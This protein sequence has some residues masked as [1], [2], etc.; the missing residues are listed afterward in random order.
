MPLPAPPALLFAG[1]LPQVLLLQPVS[2][3]FFPEVVKNLG[4][5]HMYYKN[6]ISGPLNPALIVTMHKN[7]TNML[8]TTFGPQ[9]PMKNE[10]FKPPIY[11]L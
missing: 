7:A 1:T 4:L 5:E 11:G 8:P 6:F 9:V 2:L 3:F 10:G